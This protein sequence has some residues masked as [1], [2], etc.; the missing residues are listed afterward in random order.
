MKGNIDPA[1]CISQKRRRKNFNWAPDLK[2]GG[3]RW[4]LIT[5]LQIL[6]YWIV[7]KAKIRYILGVYTVLLTVSL[8]DGMIGNKEFSFSTHRE[9]RRSMMWYSK[10]FVEVIFL[11]DSHS[12][13][14]SLLFST[15]L[16]IA[17]LALRSAKC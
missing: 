3:R 1:S 9:L 15:S 2:R 10:Y 13:F 14:R 4:S 8:F 7:A 6:I 5:S 16:L 12:I 17:F 11:F